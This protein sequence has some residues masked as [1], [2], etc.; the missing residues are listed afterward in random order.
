MFTKRETT[1]M[2]I[3][4]LIGL[5]VLMIENQYL[6][7][8]SFMVMDLSHGQ[9]TNNLLCLRHQPKLNTKYIILQHPKHYGLYN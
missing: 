2:V 3:R 7:I 8:V 4:M 6:V 5:N 1:F 9:V